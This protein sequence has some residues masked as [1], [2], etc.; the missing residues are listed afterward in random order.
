M[1][2]IGNTYTLQPHYPLKFNM[3]TSAT[4]TVQQKSAQKS[5]FYWPFMLNQSWRVEGLNDQP[6]PGACLARLLAP[7][8]PPSGST[9]R[10]LPGGGKPRSLHGKAPFFAAADGHW[11]TSPVQLP[12]S[13][14]QSAEPPVLEL[15]KNSWVESAG[16]TN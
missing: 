15:R 9:G 10:M 13:H 3:Q 8:M 7:A 1:H 5:H 14:H 12:R 4:M 6:L 11:D 2:Y 16:E